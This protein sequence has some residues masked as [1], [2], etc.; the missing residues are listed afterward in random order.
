[1]NGELC[2]LIDEQNYVQES[3]V[4]KKVRILTYVYV[5]HNREESRILQQKLLI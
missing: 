1:M 4:M 5:K 2:F 3:L